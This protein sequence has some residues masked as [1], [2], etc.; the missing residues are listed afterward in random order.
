M[1]NLA[2]KKVI[3]AF[4]CTA[5]FLIICGCLEPPDLEEFLKNDD[6][7]DF[8]DRINVKV[9]LINHTGHSL[10][11]GN[12]TITGLNVNRYYM[13]KILDENEVPIAVNSMQFVGAN[14][15]LTPNIT[16]IRRVTAINNLNNDYTYIVYSAPITGVMELSVATPT[17]PSSN[18]TANSSGV[19]NLSLPV[20]NYS[21]EIISEVNQA[22]DVYR[23]PVSPTPDN[24]VLHTFSGGKIALDPVGTTTDYVFYDAGNVLNKPLRFLRVVITAPPQLG[25]TI[26]FNMNDIGASV[27][28]TASPGAVINS[29]TISLT[30]AQINSGV[31]ISVGSVSAGSI[32]S[33]YKWQINGVDVVAQNTTLTINNGSLG[34]P[35]EP[36]HTVTA[37]FTINGKEY[38]RIFTILISG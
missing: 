4:F 26:T 30:L 13:V 24:P 16:G 29:N 1:R 10:T 36:E 6:V 8:V 5:V 2:Q 21:L 25:A 34:G 7:L 31:T 20:G 19:L 17:P 14:G 37:I 15:A 35:N 18:V 3:F 27:T 12:S 28:L 22:S 38:S 11:A 33:S 32:M 9:G 23:I